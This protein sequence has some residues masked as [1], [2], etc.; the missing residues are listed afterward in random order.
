MDIEDNDVFEARRILMYLYACCQR[1]F[2][3]NVIC[4][5]DTCFKTYASPQTKNKQ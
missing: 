3:R 4:I 2:K 1:V 5:I